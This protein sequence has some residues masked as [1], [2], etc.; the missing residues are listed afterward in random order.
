MH[1]ECGGG[2]QVNRVGDI[3]QEHGRAVG[4]HA[5]MEAAFPARPLDAVCVQ[6]RPNGSPTINGRA[7]TTQVVAECAEQTA[8]PTSGAAGGHHF[9]ASS[10][11]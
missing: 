11:W 3:D 10:I 1:Q 9:G 8:R 4:G 7:E 6:A 2:V 5:E